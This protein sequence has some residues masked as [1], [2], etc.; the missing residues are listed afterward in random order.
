MFLTFELLIFHQPLCVQV[1]NKV[2]A[3]D[4]ASIVHISLFNY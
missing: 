1:Q 2:M 3:I 4:S